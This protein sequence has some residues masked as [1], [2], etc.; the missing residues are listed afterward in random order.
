MKYLKHL[1][2]ANK[3]KSVLYRLTFNKLKFALKKALF[4]YELYFCV[5]F[6]KI[7]KIKYMLRILNN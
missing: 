6:D 3:K 2:N 4:I 1:A 7:G 5:Q